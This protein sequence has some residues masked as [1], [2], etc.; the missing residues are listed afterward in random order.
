VRHA[1]NAVGKHCVTLVDAVP[2]DGGA[3]TDHVVSHVD[4]EIVSPAS[5]NS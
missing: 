3:V 1:G 5:D 4:S 2:V